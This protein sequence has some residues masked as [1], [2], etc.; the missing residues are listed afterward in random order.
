MIPAPITEV[1][2]ALVDPE[3]LSAWVPPGDM[4]GTI[5]RFEPRP[6]GS[7]RMV[8]RY[9]D[10]SPSQGR[11]T[12]DTEVVE[13]RFI[14][15]VSNRRVVYPVDVVSD[16]P[17]DSE[18]MTMRRELTDTDGGT[19]VK[20]TADNVPDAVSAHDHAAG[21]ESSLEKLAAY[22]AGWDHRLSLIAGHEPVL[23]L[24]GDCSQDRRYPAPAASPIVATV[25][26]TDP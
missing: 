14:D 3:A 22:V 26:G 13:A 1:Y 25:A 2:A 7:Y 4:T 5:E 9:P 12:S 20:I 17:D 19:L 16:D 15:L 23:R 11:T 10:H 6:G 8:L 21:L 18:A 24:F